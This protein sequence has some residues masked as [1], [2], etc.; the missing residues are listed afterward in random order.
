MPILRASAR[1]LT[2]P[3]AQRQGKEMKSPLSLRWR[4]K[5]GV[6]EARLEDGEITVC[7]LPASETLTVAV[8]GRVT[9]DSSP[10]LR[11]VLL[12]LL[13]GSTVPAMV[14]DMSA[15]SYL[16]V[17]GIATLLE[18]LKA[19]VEG[20][21]KLRLAGMSGQVRTLAE[22]AQLDRIFHAWGSEVDLT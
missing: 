19:A 13:H 2:R 3:P 6:E 17:S 8:S 14:V 20:S 9:I 15:V 1:G 12:R 18:A 5:A 22:I 21:V 7:V 16:D 10:H 11:S 4:K